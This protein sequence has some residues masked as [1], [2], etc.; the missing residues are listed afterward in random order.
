[1]EANEKQ[2]VE[3]HLLKAYGMHP[4]TP[5]YKLLE[6]LLKEESLV[7]Q[8]VGYDEAV[9]LRKELWFLKF[10]CGMRWNKIII[11]DEVYFKYYVNVMG[12]TPKNHEE[13]KIF[14]DKDWDYN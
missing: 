9:S 6:R 8:E 7:F 2:A 13:G 1:M 10:E 3:A 11:N 4:A 12:L 14:Y 5:R